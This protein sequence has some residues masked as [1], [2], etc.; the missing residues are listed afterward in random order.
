[1]TSTLRC[2]TDFFFPRGKTGNQVLIVRRRLDDV[3][4]KIIARI[5]SVRFLQDKT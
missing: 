3:K 5:F 4:A 2:A 1:M